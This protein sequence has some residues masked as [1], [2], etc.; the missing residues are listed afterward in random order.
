MIQRNTTDPTPLLPPAV[1]ETKTGDPETWVD[2][3]KK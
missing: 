2:P 3:G 1:E